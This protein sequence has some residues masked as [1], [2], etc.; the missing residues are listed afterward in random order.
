MMILGTSYRGANEFGGTEFSIVHMVH[1]FHVPNRYGNRET[2]ARQG[3]DPRRAFAEWVA[4]VPLW[5]G[6][7][8]GPGGTCTLGDEVRRPLPALA[9]PKRKPRG[10]SDSTRFLES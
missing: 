7:G 3:L 10:A 8:G 9:R 2:K 1:T 6:E 4:T 5:K